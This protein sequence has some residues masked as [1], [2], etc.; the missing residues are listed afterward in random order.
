[1]N[2]FQKSYD[3]FS[4]LKKEDLN[5]IHLFYDAEAYFKDPFNEIKGVDQIK[6]IF[7]DMFEKL[8]NPKF[9]ILE[10]IE[11]DNQAYLTWDFTFILKSIEYKIHGSSHLKFN[12][13][14]LIN[15]NR[16]YWD[17]G[18]ELLLKLPVIK[19]FYRFMSKSFS[20]ARTKV[21]Q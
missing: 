16:D 7:S 14:K 21:N 13:Q 2:K 3:F 17:V 10:I 19:Y 15:Y 12:E 4:H 9:T 8:K 20:S 6:I 1:M 11:N 5:S 18:E